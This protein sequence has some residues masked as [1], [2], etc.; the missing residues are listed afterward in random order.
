[1]LLRIELNNLAD[2]G[3]D[4]NRRYKL[5][6]GFAVGANIEAFALALFRHSQADR[7]FDSLPNDESR[8]HLE[9]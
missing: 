3:A 9:R 1:M 8:Q 4:V 6:G 5:G 7:P 2:T